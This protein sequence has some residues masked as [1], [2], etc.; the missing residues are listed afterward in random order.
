MVIRL[1]V[2]LEELEI[3]LTDLRSLL[4]TVIDAMDGEA[5]KG[6]VQIA[7]EYLDAR[8][9]R[10]HELIVNSNQEAKE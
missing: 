5:Q 2:E 7:A 6:A 3:R 4:Y 9:N 8:L 10:I 1:L